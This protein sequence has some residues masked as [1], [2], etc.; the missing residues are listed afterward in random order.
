MKHVLW[1]ARNAARP[2]RGSHAAVAAAGG[3]DHGRSRFGESSLSIRSPLE[4]LP[5]KPPA[6]KALHFAGLTSPHWAAHESA[7]TSSRPSWR[8]PL[9]FL[10]PR[11]RDIRGCS[12]KSASAR[13]DEFD[14]H[15]LNTGLRTGG[16]D[17]R[18]ARR[19]GIYLTK[20]GDRHKT[21]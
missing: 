8:V 17:S 16:T 21:F 15:V 2:R 19:R 10:G 6:T 4:W 20:E 14:D 3:G 1:Q 11:T 12:A 18:S 13:S 5:R 7:L 9:G